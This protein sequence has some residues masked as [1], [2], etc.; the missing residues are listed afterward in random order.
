MLVILMLKFLLPATT[1]L[2]L[3]VVTVIVVI[4]LEQMNEKVVIR[5]CLNL[6]PYLFN[7]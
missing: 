4:D 7:L 3:L 5:S 6:H 2:K 1:L